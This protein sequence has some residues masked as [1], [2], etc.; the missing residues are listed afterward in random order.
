M[1]FRKRSLRK[2][3]YR[4][5]VIDH[6]VRIVKVQESLVKLRELLKIKNFGRNLV[7]GIASWAMDGGF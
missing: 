5:W 1:D 4:Q 3:G 2:D 6:C 7:L